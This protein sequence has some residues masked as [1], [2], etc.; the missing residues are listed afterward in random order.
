MPSAW[1]FLESLPLTPGGKL[2]RSALPAPDYRALPAGRARRS[3]AEQL[4]CDVFAE[5]LSFPKVSIN[6]NFFDIGGN[7]L[8]TVRL[9]KRIKTVLGVEVPLRDFYRGPTARELTALINSGSGR[10]SSIQ[11]GWTDGPAKGT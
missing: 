9:I 7:S 6:D 3:A 5:L 1:V 4:L 10:L 8:I 2:D 11:Q